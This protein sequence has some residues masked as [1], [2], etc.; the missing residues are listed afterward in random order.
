MKKLL[1]I[2]VSI[3]TAGVL[4]REEVITVNLYDT[5][6]LI[7]Y[8]LIA[9]GLLIPLNIIVLTLYLRKWSRSSEKEEV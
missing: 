7:S 1:L 4:F 8:S 9:I 5:Y 3:L 2:S 6:F